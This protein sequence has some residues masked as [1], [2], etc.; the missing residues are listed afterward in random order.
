L[1]VPGGDDG[2]SGVLI[3]GENWISYKNQG[4]AEIRTPIPRRSDTP[5]SR[6]VLIT[7]GVLH[8][9]KTGFFFL[10]QSE[11]GDLYKVALHLAPDNLKIVQNVQVVVFDSIMPANSFCI[12]RMGLLY[13]A[14]EFSN[15]ALFQFQGLADDPSAVTANSV[16]DDELGDDAESAAK[17][18]KLFTPSPR[19]RN[20]LQVDDVPSVS[21]TIDALIETDSD[22]GAGDNAA[23]MGTTD[24]G[25]A[26]IYTVCGTGIRSS[27][28]LLQPGVPVTEVAKSELPGRPTGVWSIAEV[29]T[30]DADSGSTQAPLDRYI[31]V[32]FTAT[33]IVLAVGDNVQQ[34]N[35]SGFL[36]TAGTMQAALMADGSLI[37]V[38]CG[39]IR[40]IRG[41]AARGDQRTSE[42][43]PPRERSIDHASVNNRQV[44]ISLVKAA[45][46]EQTEIIYFELNAAGQLTEIAASGVV[47]GGASV[48][49]LD[50][51]PVAAGRA[52]SS[53]LAIGSNDNTVQLL[54]L[55]PSDMLQQRALMTVSAAPEALCLV[56]MSR[57]SGAAVPTNSLPAGGGQQVVSWTRTHV[58]TVVPVCGPD[59]RSAC[60]RVCG[61]SVW[62]LVRLAST[63][64][65]PPCCAPEPCQS[66]GAACRR[67]AVDATLA[68]LQLARRAPPSTARIRSSRSL[69]LSLL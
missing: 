8:K 6:G 64:P 69:Q 50:L 18:A 30:G 56:P 31:V 24:L 61:F 28:R 27:L 26:R 15:Q 37:Q 20:L 2:P 39:G 55:E 67:R 59:F 66:E 33:T 1:S 34:V 63:L 11:L 25:A 47:P 53:F 65:R 52:R 13:I 35:D 19:L 12:T 54:S 16:F 4:H 57:L 51:G 45:G 5:T 46:D 62:R 38:H 48:T 7:F 29:N 10:V 44:A 21:P 17:V 43:K 14:S 40:H 49:A 9:Q 3:C 58:Y 32:S 68:H 22:A 60:A 23:A 36:A 42:W 41:S